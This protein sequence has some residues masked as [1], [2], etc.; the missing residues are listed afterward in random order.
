MN[1]DM[2]PEHRND[3]RRA[4]PR[5]ETVFDAQLEFEGEVLE[6]RIVDISFGGA[7]FVTTSVDPPIAAGSHVVLTVEP[8]P[9]A[10]ASELTWAG[11]IVR[12]ERSGDDGPDRFAYA[13]S[14]DDKAPRRIPGLNGADV[15]D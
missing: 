10:G 12:A 13:I 1:P 7:K 4:D 15:V 14:F 8:G 5:T 11:T 2:E 6:G 3:D 9:V